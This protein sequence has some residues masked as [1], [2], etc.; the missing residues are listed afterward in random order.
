[1]KVLIL[2]ILFL[3]CS[4]DN[5]EKIPCGNG[6][7]DYGEDC[8]TFTSKSCSDFGYYEGITSCNNDCTINI[9]NCRGRCGDNILQTEFGE[10]CDTSENITSSCAELGY[11]FQISNTISCSNCHITGCSNYLK[12]DFSSEYDFRLLKADSNGNI[13][14]IGTKYLSGTTYLSVAKLNENL[15]L[16]WIKDVADG[17][18]ASGSIYLTAQVAEVDSDDNIVISG[19][20]NYKFFNFSTYGEDD[21]YAL[22]INPTGDV[23]WKNTFGDTKYDDTFGAAFDSTDNA[24]ICGSI[25]LDVGYTAFPEYNS[26]LLKYDAGGSIFY[27]ES[28]SL[29]RFSNFYDIAIDYNNDII[30]AKFNS[31]YQYPDYYSIGAVLKYDQDLNEIWSDYFNFTGYYSR[32]EEVIIAEDNSIIALGYTN[33]SLIPN[34]TGNFIARYGTQGNL[35]WLKQGDDYKQQHGLTYYNNAFHMIS[36]KILYSY[37]L[38][39]EI[40]KQLDTTNSVMSFGLYNNKMFYLSETNDHQFVKVLKLEMANK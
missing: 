22:K 37:N 17:G 11:S 38:Y 31:A 18:T 2:I 14:V 34:A 27:E 8:D 21:V 39:G 13:Y 10:E 25:E 30:L 26:M 35:I 4:C 5:S 36:D 16:Q 40:I 15:E 33:Y 7:L 20:F 3:L 24:Y 6:K 28:L 12:Y 23:I 29:G 9:E 19:T 32:V 1:M